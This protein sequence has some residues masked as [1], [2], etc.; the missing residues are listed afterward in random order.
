MRHEGAVNHG[1]LVA[2]VWRI[3]RS[4]L[5]GAAAK[6]LR[7]LDEAEDCAQDALLAALDAWPRA[8]LPANPAAWLMTATRHKALDRL[9][10]RTM[11]QREHEALAADDAAA[12]AH[13]EPDFVDRLDAARDQ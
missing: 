8:G 2:G 1:E 9:R 7:D 5:V 3:E 10:R 12:G 13:V 6:L 4:R 11:L